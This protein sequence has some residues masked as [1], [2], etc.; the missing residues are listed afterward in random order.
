[1]T[2][3]LVWLDMAKGFGI[4]SV[5]AY[6]TLKGLLNSSPDLPLWVEISANYLSLWL[7]PM[8][9]IVSGILSKNTIL[10]ASTYKIRKK[11]IN[12]IYLYLIW[13]FIIYSVRLT[14][15]NITNTHMEMSEILYI[16]C[17]PV[18]TIW[19]IYALLL[20][21]IF[22]RLIKSINANIIFIGLLCRTIY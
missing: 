20:S 22:T 19:F 3:Q 8:F 12:W 2:E 16:L 5:V 21:F 9:F 13:S 10:N 4:V 11:I 17:D 1:M 18:P 6:H 15:N 14:F 7:M